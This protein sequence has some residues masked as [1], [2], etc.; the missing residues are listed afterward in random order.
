MILS[1]TTLTHLLSFCIGRAKRQTY[2]CRARS[3][4]ALL[5]L[6]H[7]GLRE[8]FIRTKAFEDYIRDNVVSWFTWAQ[9]NKLGVERMEELILVTGCTLVT[10]WAAAAFHDTTVDATSISM[11]AQKFDRGGAQFFW[12]NRRGK[13]ECHHSLF[14]PVRSPDYVLPQYSYSSLY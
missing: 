3:R 4:G 2:T 7:G 13:V 11:G 9:K 8:D 1:W 14:N 10:S 5:S 6:P 12:R